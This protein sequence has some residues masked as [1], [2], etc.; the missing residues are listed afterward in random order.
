MTINCL[1]LG[2]CVP[3]IPLLGTPVHI[4]T[5]TTTTKNQTKQKPDSVSPNQSF[6]AEGY[7]NNNPYNTIFVMIFTPLSKATCI[8]TSH[9]HN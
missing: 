9:L 1:G 8:Y 6:L 5:T 4:L 2:T 7:N 3:I